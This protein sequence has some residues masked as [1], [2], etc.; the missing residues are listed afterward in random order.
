MNYSNLAFKL[1]FLKNYLAVKDIMTGLNYR[2]IY[3]LNFKSKQWGH[4]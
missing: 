4:R 2:R 3:T 1:T